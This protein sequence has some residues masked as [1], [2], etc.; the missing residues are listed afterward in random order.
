MSDPTPNTTPA[1]PRPKRWPTVL[2]VISLA[3]NLAVL[4]A[5]A[6]AHVR[7]R[8]DAALLPP[9]ERMAVGDTGIGP[10]IDALP[11]DMRGRMGQ[12]LRAHGGLAPDRAALAQDFRSMLAA[13]RAEPYDSDALAAVL[14]A[15]RARFEARV[16]QSQAVLL[17]EIAAMSPADRAAFADRLERQF[18]HAM[19]R[20][21]HGPPAG[22][23][24]ANR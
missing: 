17:D 1:A 6:G 20:G 21:P 3:L 16:T 24:G 2:L 18:R 19:E 14:K 8:R 23:P 4:G 5:I 10:F 12:A 7:D 13:L 22:R 11:R 15:Q 9:P